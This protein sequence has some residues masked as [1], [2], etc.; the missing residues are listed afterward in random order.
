MV[1]GVNRRCHRRSTE[2]QA[3]F[4]RLLSKLDNVPAAQRYALPSTRQTV[5]RHRHGVITNPSAFDMGYSCK[6]AYAGLPT[7]RYGARLLSVK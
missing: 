7:D 4:Y 1:N 3:A 5:R 2:G 6:R